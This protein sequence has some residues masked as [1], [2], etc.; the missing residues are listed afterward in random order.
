MTEAKALKLA[1]K[2]SEIAREL[3]DYNE[4]KIAAKLSGAED[5]EG[6]DFRPPILPCTTIINGY[7]VNINCK[8]GEIIP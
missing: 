8:T 7:V 6:E 5:P 4:A 2:A 1:R 3:N